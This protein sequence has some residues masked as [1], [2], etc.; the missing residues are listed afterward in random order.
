MKGR[1]WTLCGTPEYLAPEII[2]SKGYGKS[3]DWWSFGVLIYEMAAGYPPFYS[4]D[5]MKIYEKI[6]SGKFKYVNHFSMELKD[7]IKNMLQ[8]DLSRRFRCDK[9][10]KLVALKHLLQV[11]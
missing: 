11:R 6:V 9:N 4:Q 1:T 3:A 8:V 2:L 5:P 7:L 10:A